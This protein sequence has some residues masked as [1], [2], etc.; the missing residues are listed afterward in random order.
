MPVGLAVGEISTGRRAGLPGSETEPAAKSVPTGVPRLGFG[1]R[2]QRCR[3]GTVSLSY[4]PAD[5]P[6]WAPPRAKLPGSAAQAGRSRP[7]ADEK[8]PPRPTALQSIPFASCR[9][10]RSIGS[11]AAPVAPAV[12]EIYGGAGAK[13]PGSVAA[14]PEPSLA[15]ATRKPGERCYPEAHPPAQAENEA[16][17]PE[18]KPNTLRR[19][20]GQVRTRLPGSGPATSGLTLTL[21]H[22]KG[23]AG[24]PWR[25][26]A[27]HVTRKRGGTRTRGGPDATAQVRAKLPG[28]RPAPDEHPTNPTIP[29]I[30]RPR[31][32]V[33]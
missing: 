21:H 12:R 28:S 14:R 8:H 3:F 19:M 1:S 27:S 17:Y 29:P 5:P 10:A 16:G 6:L 31:A 11:T 26:S 23:A 2:A 22:P 7:G 32:A 9:R 4:R 18:A 20:A 25:P 33:I 24:R 15:Q 30:S 13:L